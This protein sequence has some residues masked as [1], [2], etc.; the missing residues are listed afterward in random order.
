MN[1]LTSLHNKTQEVA[2]GELPFNPVNRLLTAADLRKL[3]DENGLE[4]VE[5]H[6][7]NLYRNAFVHRSYCTMKNEDFAAG[8][9]R[10]P[11]DCLPLQEMSYERM[12]FLGDA[13]LGMVVA[14]YLYERFPDQAE[15]FLSKMRTKLVNGKML[16]TLSAKI[17]LGP[18]AII[19]KQVEEANGRRSVNVLEDIFE[20]MIGAVYMDFQ[21]PETDD[22]VLANKSVTPLTGG[23][24]H[25]AELWIVG[26]LE[27]CIDFADLICARTNY[28]D[29]LVRHMQHTFQDGPRF[30]EMGVNIRN[31]VKVFNYCVKDRDGTTLGIGTGAS[32]KD[33]ENI[34]AQAALKY[35][36]AG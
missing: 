10:R 16:A 5:F 22:V 19:S 17:G 27:R 9:E 29:M 36:G 31:S 26:I 4:N 33:A 25:I 6:N 23:G 8:N 15:G 11:P 12:E 18:F 28:K 2:T 14:R 1:R 24:Y 13:I 32:K 34:A 35:Y 20:A 30:F 7:I 3:F 21:T